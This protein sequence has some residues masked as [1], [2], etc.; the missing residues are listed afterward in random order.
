MKAAFRAILALGLV[1]GL[2]GK[3]SAQGVTTGSINGTVVDEQGQVVPGASIVAVHVPSGSKYETVTRGDGGFSIPGMRVG[4]P[5]TV[6]ASLS[7][8][9]DGVQ[10]EIYVVLGGTRDLSLTLRTGGVSEEI[11]VTAAVDPVF[12]SGR[13]GAATSVDRE[14]LDTMPTVTDRL[15]SFTRLTPQFS[16]S[17]SFVG[18]DN[19]LNNITIDGSYFN[20][21]FGLA[22]AP[23]DRTGVA[24]IAMA[25][26][27]AVQVNIAPYDVRQGNFVGAGVNSVTRSG[28][29]E[30]R[31]SAYYWFRDEGL[32]GTEAGD[33]TVNPGT[34]DFKKIG[35]WISGP[36]VKDKLFFFGSVE[37]ETLTSPGTTFRANAGGESIGGNTTRVLASDLDALSSFLSSRFQYETGPYQDYDHET[38]AR[39]YLAKIDWNLSNTNKVVLRYN[40]LDSNTDVLLSN[41]ASLGFGNRRTNLNGLNFQNSNYMIL[42]NIRSFIGEWNSIIG[43]NN[44]NTLIAGY[45]KQ[46][47]SRDSRGTFFPMVD[48]L[49]GGSV[50]TTFGFEPFTPNNE[51]RYNTFQVQNNFT[52]HRG[53]HAITFGASVQRYESE[54]VF[55]S[56][57]QS[58]Y[59]YNSL[60]D[61]Y[62]DANGYL[63]NPNRTTSP[64]T[65][66]LFQVR[67]NNIPGQEKPI[68]PLEVWYSG[69][70]AQD[71]WEASRNLKVTY[72]LRIDVPKFGNTAYSNPEFDALALRDEDGSP[73]QYQTGKLPDARIL[74]SPRVGVN[75]DVTG[76]RTLQVRGGTGVFTGPPAYVWISNQIG[77]T[78]VLTGSESLSNTTARPFNPNPDRYKPA[79]VTGAPTLSGEFA[80]TDPD[81]KFPQVWRTN[82]AVDRKLPWNVVATAEMIYSR[83]VNGIYY[84]N[85]NLPAPQAAFQG[86]DNRPRWTSNRIYSPVTN[87]IVLKNQNEGSSFHVSSTLERTFSAGF[88]RASYGWGTA[89]NTVDPGSIAAGSFLANQHSGNPNDPGI[90]YSTGRPGHRFFVAGSYKLDWLKFGSTTFSLFWDNFSG[91]TS[92]YIFS[93]DFNGDGGSANDLIYVHRD[94]SEMNFVAYSSGGRTY[95]AAEQA[96]AWDAY[97]AQDPYLSKRRG[98]Y[99]ERNGVLL[100]MVSRADLSVTQDLFTNIGGK[101]H[102]LQ[103]RAD[104]LNVGN[105]I[106]KNWGLSQFL[107]STSPLVVP[108]SNAGG[109]VDASGRPRYTLRNI[110]G[111]LMNTS[112]QKSASINDVYRVQFSLRYN[113][114]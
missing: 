65:L 11:T 32:V 9:T 80:L 90:A 40:H 6:T 105:L 57:S 23:G 60:A 56:G 20:N 68:Q 15:D 66:R 91:G 75:W 67:Y 25:A 63:A 74:W 108:A 59:V 18:Q 95:S 71:E 64:V 43:G 42:E 53:K 24:P 41:S 70:Y 103:F 84:I 13:T 89:K 38:P 37:D 47:E 45:T 107:T 92:S 1:L 5:Y 12:S 61:F 96:A 51:L 17:G 99:A 55:F 28:G 114:N 48:I 27:E 86:A 31:G 33:R 52:M 39:R 4:G 110:G 19:R 34:F 111:Q 58:I 106:S 97:I 7:G 109:P 8:F 93:G 81:F 69:L 78:G 87:A 62:T 79:N 73:V 104:I 94:Q 100:P 29:N 85:A 14:V 30:F 102:S 76:D 98:Q 10:K 50:Y 16:G 26:I 77:N 46:D 83:D 3:A 22:G 82:L 101:K 44:S 113:F 36:I 21:S 112:F 49:S 72:G 2:A 35:G 54:N 88:I